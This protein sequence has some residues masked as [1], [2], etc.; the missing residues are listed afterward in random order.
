MKIRVENGLEETNPIG[1]G[2]PGELDTVLT[3]AEQVLSGG[4]A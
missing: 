2:S 1:A 3:A 4:E